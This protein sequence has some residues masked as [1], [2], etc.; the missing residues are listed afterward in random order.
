MIEHLRFILIIAGIA[1]ALVLLIRS[2]GQN[3]NDKWPKG[4]GFVG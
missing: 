2:R 1:L 3:D 4:P